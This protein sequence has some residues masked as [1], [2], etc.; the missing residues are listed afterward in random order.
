MPQERLQ[1]HH[2]ADLK[3]SGLSDE[4]IQASGCYS[5]QEPTVR[6]LLG[7]GVGPG[8]VIPFPGCTLAGGET[9]FVQVKPDTPPEWLKRAKYITPKESGC[10][11]YIPP[12]IPA[13][14]LADPSRPLYLTE[15]VKKA[16][17][18]TQEGLLTLAIAGVDAW[19]DTRTGK[20]API[21]DLDKVVW[22][23]RSV[24]ITYDSDLAYKLPVLQAE[25]KLSRELRS[26]GAQVKAIRLPNV[27]G[28]KVGLDDYLLNHS[29]E[30]FCS[31]EAVLIRP[32]PATGAVLIQVQDLSEFLHSKPRRVESLIGDGI[33]PVKGT[34]VE[35]GPAKLGKSLFAMNAGL[36]L[37]LGKPFLRW[38]VPKRQKVL[39]L[40]A[41]ISEEA[42][43]DRFSKMLGAVEGGL[44][45][46]EG[47]FS[48]ATKKGL[49]LD[50]RTGFEAV[51]RMMET[52]KPGVLIIDPLRR[53]LK[54]DE[55]K[56]GE[57][58]NFFDLLDRFIEQTGCSIILVH[59]FG[60]PSKDEQKDG[61][62]HLRGSSV[63]FDVGDAYLSLQRK[64]LKES[65]R[66][67]RLTC[68]LRNADDPPPMELYR[69][70]ETLWMHEVE[71]DT[72]KCTVAAVHAIVSLAGSVSGKILTERLME[73]Y[74]VGDRLARSQISEAV[75]L[76]M[77]KRLP[78]DGTK[79]KS[80]TYC[81]NTIESTG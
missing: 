19:K 71:G 70:P 15:G 79:G 3:S 13:D 54:G 20:P 52:V 69:D 36:C 67:I 56:S 39:Y 21:P 63:I 23:G 73:T 41:E 77:I 14:H 53:F 17:K 49:K 44:E 57:V 74:G 47:W 55:N 40:Q 51:Q 46:V 22:R 42:L 43:W 28:H 10:R 72:S 31:L 35:G 60:K 59:H 24:Y 11:L 45:A 8:L 4:T 75:S 76:G 80:F 5:A 68:E 30:A 61:A 78:I 48:L 33:L 2:L 16:L 62:Q 34:Q 32:V 58:G 81:I 12:M 1:A 6:M 66:H 37:A 25:F 65:K 9:P 26:R 50:T 27:N 64:S 29:I 7:F 38:P 18:A